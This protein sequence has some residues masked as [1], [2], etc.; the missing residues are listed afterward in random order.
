MAA[1]MTSRQGHLASYQLGRFVQ[2]LVL[3]CL[4]CA[5]IAGCQVKFVSDYDETTD[6]MATDLQKKIDNKF[7]EWLRLPP[8]SPT[9][10]YSANTAFYADVDGDLR[11]LRARAL[12]QPL[13]KDTLGIIDAIQNSVQTIEQQHRKAGTISLAALGSAENQ[14]DFQFQQLIQLELAKKRGS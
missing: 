14:L 9:L 11:A 10:Q 12:A 1:M 8:G 4:I 5:A 7:G 2:Q 3:L 13:N 6:K